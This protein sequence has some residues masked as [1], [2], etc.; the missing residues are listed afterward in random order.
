MEGLAIS[1]SY[2][3]HAPL[4]VTQEHFLVTTSTQMDYATRSARRPS[5]SVR[6]NQRAKRRGT[7]R[8][9]R[10]IPCGGGGSRRAAL[11]RNGGRVSGG[12]LRKRRRERSICRPSGEGRRAQTARNGCVTKR[13]PGFPTRTVG[14]PINRGKAPSAISGQA[15]AHEAKSIAG[16]TAVPGAIMGVERRWRGSAAPGVMT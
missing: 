7:I 10:A 3:A 5:A 1:C 2:S 12:A 8:G 4:S 14:T 9:R 13:M 16:H 6:K 15:G 11:R